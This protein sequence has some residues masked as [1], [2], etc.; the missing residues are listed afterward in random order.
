MKYFPKGIGVKVAF[1]PDESLFGHLL[2]YQFFP[3]QGYHF[4]NGLRESGDVFLF[5]DLGRS[6]VSLNISQI[7][8]KGEK[9]S[10]KAEKT[11][12]FF[13]MEEKNGELSLAGDFEGV[14]H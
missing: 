10:A 5:C 11:R 4:G 12:F 2:V 14:C 7:F 3:C 8:C 6:G 1:D 9:L 13:G